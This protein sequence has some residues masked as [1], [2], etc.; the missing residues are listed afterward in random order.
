MRIQVIVDGA[1]KERIARRAHIEGLSMSAWIRRAAL[2]ELDA[3]HP[4][5]RAQRIKAIFA[6]SD[7]LASEGP[8]PDWEESKR[9]LEEGRDDLD[10][11][12]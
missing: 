4:G 10:T 6:A 8:E 2:R 11:G 9:L 3:Q 1:D 7:A 5:G 12:T